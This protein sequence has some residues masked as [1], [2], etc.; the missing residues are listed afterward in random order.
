M[1]AR[2]IR[3]WLG[4]P[5]VEIEEINTRLETTQWF[6]DNESKARLIREELGKVSDVERLVGRTKNGTAIPREIVALGRSLEIIPQL[7]KLLFSENNDAIKWLTEN[8]PECHET[9]TTIRDAIEQEPGQVG[10][11]TVIKRGYS[12]ELDHFLTSSADARN[13][14]SK[15]ETQERETTGIKNLKVGYNKVFGYYIE[16][17]NPHL[18]KEIEK[19]N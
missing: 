4:Q 14:I 5:L 16:I 6:F 13:Y 8:I 17:T 12:A 7:S 1:G 11:G 19:I 9:A 3:R 18:S 10:D 15:L 2:L